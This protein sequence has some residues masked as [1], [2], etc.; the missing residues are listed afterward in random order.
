MSLEKTV[1]SSTPGRVLY[2]SLPGLY[3]I[4]VIM[5]IKD[6][7]DRLQKVFESVALEVLI[8]AGWTVVDENPLVLSHVDHGLSSLDDAWILFSEKE[9]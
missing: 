9:E 5:E 7:V 3:L 4:G 6:D 1:L 2:V 8:N